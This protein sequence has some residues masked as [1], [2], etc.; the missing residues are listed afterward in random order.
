[1]TDTMKQARRLANFGAALALLVACTALALAPASAAEDAAASDTGAVNWFGGAVYDGDP[2][3]ETTAALVEA[4]GGADDFSFSTALVSMLGE[5]T[6]NAEVE[7]LQEQY[8]EERV[9]GFVDGMTWA[10]NDGLK[11]ATE[12]GVSLPEAPADLTGEKLARTLVEAGTTPDGTFWSGHLF[13]KTLSHQIHNQVM[14]DIEA[15]FGHE[16]DEDTHRILNQAMYD[17]AQALGMDE[18]QLADLH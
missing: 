13:D 8:G 3:L 5:D 17:V 14:A 18:V 16:A 6:V 15:E 2:D 9:Q 7:K 1:M 12:A 4:G 11:R 10:V